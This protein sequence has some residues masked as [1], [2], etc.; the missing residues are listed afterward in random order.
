MFFQIYFYV[1]IVHLKTILQLTV[2]VFIVQQKIYMESYWKKCL[3]VN[4]KIKTRMKDDIFTDASAV[5]YLKM[6]KH[7]DQVSDMYCVKFFCLL[8]ACI[9]KVH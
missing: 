4:K 2:N 5:K 1:S 6:L 3:K 8:Y 7:K 9:C